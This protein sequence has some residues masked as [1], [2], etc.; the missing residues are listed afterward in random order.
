MAAVAES[1]RAMSLTMLRGA[2]FDFLT[3]RLDVPLAD[4]QRCQP[5]KLARR[6]RLPQGTL[7]RDDRGSA[8]GR[9]PG[10]KLGGGGFPKQYVSNE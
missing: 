1:G 7:E 6:V 5:S 10:F 3:F 8:N 2:R 9:P 4:R